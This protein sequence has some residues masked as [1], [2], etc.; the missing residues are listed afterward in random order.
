ML[1]EMRR[2]STLW[3]T[4]AAAWSVLLVLNMLRHRTANTVVIGV[5]VAA[6]VVVGAIYRWRESKQL[7]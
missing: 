4:L 6:F 2:Q 7:K 3:F 1:R 5:A